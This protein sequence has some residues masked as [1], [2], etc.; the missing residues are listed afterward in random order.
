MF[1][2]YLKHQQFIR[3]GIEEVCTFL[4]T[5]YFDEKCLGYEEI[6]NSLI[7]NGANANTADDEGVSALY[8]AASNG[9]LF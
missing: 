3:S 7:H 8:A 1:I 2:F 4:I 6:V 9:D 5:T